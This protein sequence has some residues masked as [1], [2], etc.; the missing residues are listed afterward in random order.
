M[1]TASILSR[2]TAPGIKPDVTDASRDDLAVG[3]VVELESVNVGTAYQWS[4]AFKPE[5]QSGTPSTAVF[6]STGTEQAI[7]KDPGTFT[8]DL[9]GPYLLRL[10][11]TTPQITLNTVLAAGVTFTINGITLTAVAGARTPGSDDFSIASG[12]AAGV[13]ADIVAAIND[14]ANSF[15]AAN[16]AGTNASPSVVISPT[17]A[18]VPTGETIGITYSGSASDVT[19]GDL[20]TEQYVRLRALTAFGDLKLV[21]AGERYDTLRVPVDAEPDGWADNQNYNLNQLLGL[22]GSSAASTGVVYVDPVNGDFQTIQAAMDYANAQTPTLAQQWVVL[23]R[24]GTYVEDLTF[25]QWVHVFGWPGGEGTPLVTVQNDTAASH[26]INLP[27]AGSSLTLCNL[28]FERTAVSANAVILQGANGTV[29]LVRCQIEGSGA[30]GAYESLGFVTFTDCEI[31]GGGVAVADFALTFEGNALLERTNVS[32]QSCISVAVTS[33]N[34]VLRDCTLTTAGSFAVNSRGES[35]TLEYCTAT[36]LLAGNFGGLGAPND[37]LLSVKWSNVEDITWNGLG[38]AGT[39]EA[40]VGASVVSGAAVTLNGAISS[41]SVQAGTIFYNNTVS[42]LTAENVQ[43]A[44]DEVYAFAALVR[45]LDDAY[46]GGVVGSGSGRTIIADQG[47]VQIVDAPAPS[48]PIPAGNTNGNLEVVGSIKL[49]GINKPEITVDPNPFG[50]GPTILLGKEIWANDAPYGSTALI[51][52]DASGNP[53]FHNYNLR[54]GTQ[55]ADGGNQVGSVFVRAGDSLTTID[56]GAVYIQGGTA[57]DAGG[58]TGGDVI[59]VP[60][61][62]AAG[63]ARAMVLANPLTAT[64]AT[65]TAAGAFSGAAVAGEITIG[66]ELGAVTVTF[67]GGENLAAVHAL[68]DATGVVTAAGDP[69]VLTTV[70]KGGTAE[71]FFISADAG[72]DAALGVFSGQAMVAGTWPDQV[73]LGASAPNTL[74][75]GVNAPNP[76][77]YN[78]A[79]G[80]LTVPGLIDPT[81]VIFDEAGTPATG[82]AKGGVFVSDGSGGLVQN[83]L[84]YVDEAGVTTNISA[85]AAGVTNHAA[86]TNLL[87]T[88]SGHTDGGAGG[89]IA[90]FDGGTGLASLLTGATHGDIIYFDGTDF[91]ILAPGTAGNIL[92]TQGAGLPPQ[93]IAGAGTDELV[94]ATAT[95]TTPGYL[96]DKLSTATTGVSFTTLNPGANEQQRLDIASASTASQGL[97]EVATQAEVDAG[98]STSLAVVPATLSSWLSPAQGEILYFDG[99]SWNK[100]AVGT[101]GQVLQT[102]GAAA[103]PTWVTPTTGVSDHN[104]L[105]NLLWT[106][107]NHTGTANRIAAFDGGGA[108]SYLQ[109]GVD[110]QAWDT[111]LDALAGLATTGLVVRTGVGTAATR[112]VTGTAGNIVVTNGNGVLGDPTIDVGAN[113]FTTA[114]ADHAALTANLAWTTSLHTGTAGTIATFDALGA[115]SEITGNQGEI[116]YYDGSAWSRLAVGTAGQVLQTNGAGADPTWVTPSSGTTDHALLSNLAWTSSAHTGTAS[117]FAAFDGLGAATNLST[118]ASG[119]DVGGTWPNLTVSDL[120]IAGEAQS[121]ILYYNG[122][123]WVRLAAGTPGQFLQTQ[124]A[125]PLWSDLPTAS[126]T[127]EGII[128]I[129]TQA[130][131][132][133]GASTTLVVTPATLANAT[134][135]ILSGQTAGGDLGGTYPNPTVTDLTIAGEAQGDILYYNG[136]N[137]VRLAAGTSG[138]LLQTNGAGANPSWVTSSATD[139]LVGVSAAD[140]TPGYLSDKLITATTGVGFTTLNPGADEDYRLDIDTASTTGQG[141]IE[142]ATQAEVDAGA[143]AT[144]AVTPSTLASATTVILSGQAAGGDLGGTYPNPTVNDGADSTAIHDNIAGEIAAI[145]LKGTPVSADILLIEDSAAGNAKKRITVGSLPTGG[146]GEANTAS[147]VNTGGVGVFKQKTGVDLEFRGVNAATAKITVAL[148]A[149]TNEIRV[150]AADASTTQAG[151]IEIATQAEVDAGASATLAVTPATLASATTIIVNGQAAGG[152]LAGT[153]PNPTVTDLTITSEAHGDI[154][155]RNATNWVRLAAGTAGQLLQTQ[156]AGAAPQWITSSATDEQVKITANDTT[157]GYLLDKLI[158]ATTG[159]AFTEINDGGDEDLRLD[160]DTA[161]TTGQ[162]LIEIATQAEVDAG[163]S[164]T[165]A[166][167]PATLASATTVIL[168][169]QAAGGDLGGTYP[170]PTVTDLTIASEAQGDILYFNGT[171]WVRL[172]PGTSGEFLQTQ[173]AAANPQWATPT[174]LDEQVKVTGADTTPGFLSDKLITATTGVAFTTLNPGADE[175][176]RLDIDTASTTGQGLIEIATQAEV[177]AGASTTLAVTPATLASATTVAT[178][179]QTAYDLGPTITTAG[180]T[181]IAFTLTSG[182]FTVGGA[183][184]V[185]LTNTGG[186]TYNNVSGPVAFGNTT[187]VASFS[188]FSASSTTLQSRDTTILTMTANDAANKTLTISASNSDPT[189]EGRISISSDSQV[190]I[191]DS[192]GTLLLDGGA[193]S[194]TGMTLVSLSPSGAVDLVA[195]AASQFTTSAGALTLDGNGGVNVVGNA[196]EVDIT[197]TGAVDINSGAGT[198]DASTL[199]LDATDD[200]NLTMTAND[201]GNKTLTISAT[202]GG[203]GLGDL[204]IDADGQITVGGT[205]VAAAT[206]QVAGGVNTEIL[207]LTQT[208]GESFGMFAGTADPSGSVT[209]NAGSLFVR[210]TGATAELYQNTSA[211]GSGTTWTQFSAGGGGITP[212]Q[213]KA[214]NDLIH[215]ID[216]GPAD[217]F[218]SGS[219]K[220]TAY[221]G[222]LVTQEIWYTSGAKTQKIVQLDVTYTGALPTTEVWQM[223]DSGGVLSVTLTDTIIYSG[224]LETSRTRTWV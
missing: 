58:G 34:V 203:G 206:V 98:A 222:G 89:S 164:T 156:G 93:W 176:Y 28:R 140:T 223:F 190:S 21:A 44:I 4:I 138:Q 153:Y 151:A 20:V 191:T 162:G 6:S 41:A 110:V 183:G 33:T 13:V 161:S 57:T 169:G 141:L 83:D 102:N 123:N 51:L 71:V 60:G 136:T 31:I 187:E 175:D 7:N 1:P 55:S 75:V 101:A 32:G 143:S 91:V 210:D 145:T 43:D 216:D 198:W 174:D 53:T 95:D 168:S 37:L 30:G 35:V 84:Y 158:T 70:A 77:L 154:L 150:D 8:V 25:Y 204:D 189:G 85:A 105:N 87:W 62:T 221:S 149:G 173:G 197:T 2:V 124:A 68:F 172:A 139:E 64:P 94:G 209:A 133:A 96:I 130:E 142:I 186:L 46:D 92:Q 224:A 108:A 81:G 113:V 152:D 181:D 19:I 74:I 10:A 207:K 112:T 125:A 122:T 104:L 166:V 63:G 201:A 88:A 12:T 217:G 132:D 78:T 167:T 49:G 76:M 120:T 26:G 218:A 192:T 17:L 179:L 185:A 184:A 114:S 56:A 121:D 72:V 220:D 100:L 61:E 195:G 97:I 126:T 128:E 67:A 215:F 159:V 18:T 213:H 14:P 40:S 69:I 54:I 134:T 171:N 147:N 165:L 29:T 16:L 22:V 131:V 11:Y 80:K 148:D 212:A 137:W 111:D 82:P 118:T 15:V 42:G 103:D 23:V 146:G 50:N 107:S 86:L 3:D 66:S 157:A 99:A 36:G 39:A 117:T 59:V 180:A 188:A 24:P 27:G 182:G 160:I 193:L 5:D 177:D 106:S 90:L 119:G 178:S 200:T 115:A 127:V 45:T 208:T 129:A 211:G 48:D 79:T 9:D 65:L 47:A 199:S 219:V 196:A 135:V 116:L 214:L 194:E 109:I 205:N 202:N 155:Y 170:N 144:L 52:G 163:A 73:T 38:V